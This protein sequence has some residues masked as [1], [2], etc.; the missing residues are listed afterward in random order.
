MQIEGGVKRQKMLE[1]DK[2]LL[3]SA[4]IEMNIIIKAKDG[5]RWTEWQ[6]IILKGK[7]E[8][9]CVEKKVAIICL[10]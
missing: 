7:T 2:Y 8:I 5:L 6:S 4:E 3:D 9:R 1:G 10:C